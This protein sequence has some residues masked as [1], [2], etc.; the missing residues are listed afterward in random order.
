MVMDEA[1]IKASDIQV[2]SAGPMAIATVLQ[3]PGEI[4][5]NDDR[6]VHVVPRVSG[7]AEAVLV[8]TG[9]SVKKGQPLAIFSS[10]MISEQRSAYK[11]HKNV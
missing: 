10:Q 5:I 8:S 9:Q 1:Q 4:Q 3:F 6:T 2:A 7:V 11:Q